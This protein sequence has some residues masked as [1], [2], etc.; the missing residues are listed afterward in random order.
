M[1]LAVMGVTAGPPVL[2][3]LPRAGVL[4]WDP[5]GP[6]ASPRP[7][8]PLVLPRLLQLA[9]LDTEQ[10]RALAVGS[11]RSGALAGAGTSS[12]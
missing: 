12:G 4:G 5:P 9:E 7:F 6:R 1:A 11:G 2:E 10:S 3:G 8:S